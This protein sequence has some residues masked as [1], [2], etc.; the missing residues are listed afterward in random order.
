MQPANAHKDPDEELYEGT[1]AG[2]VSG[3]KVN[4]LA[5][6]SVEPVEATKAMTQG[7]LKQLRCRQ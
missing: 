6:M 5:A 2:D 4:F 1:L 7:R 3:M